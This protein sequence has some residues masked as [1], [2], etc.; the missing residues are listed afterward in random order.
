MESSSLSSLV[1]KT[2]VFKPTMLSNHHLLR[3]LLRHLRFWKL[4]FSSR[5]CC[6]IRQV[7]HWNQTWNMPPPCIHIMTIC[8]R[9]PKP[10]LPKET[11]VNPRTD[12]YHY[13]NHTQI[14]SYGN[15]R[16]PQEH[17]D[18]PQSQF[19]NSASTKTD[20]YFQLFSWPPKAKK[21][22]K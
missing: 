16:F 11:I 17:N 13:T 10:R 2:K 19:S 15:S 6:P 8:T 18:Y 3:H 14:Y 5:Q 22:L 9:E 20:D 7:C 4:R 12:Y 21:K 1:L